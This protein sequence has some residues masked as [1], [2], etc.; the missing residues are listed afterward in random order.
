MKEL[1]KMDSN[2]CGVDIVHTVFN[3]CSLSGYPIYVI[4]DIFVLLI[5]DLLQFYCVVYVLVKT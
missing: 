1:I 5:A 4:S 3:I 2:P